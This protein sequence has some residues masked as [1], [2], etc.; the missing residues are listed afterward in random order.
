[1]AFHKIL[2][3]HKTVL[4][5]TILTGL[6]SFTMAQ[7]AANTAT[8]SAPSADAPVEA[9]AARK[10]AATVAPRPM[11]PQQKFVVDTVKMAT[12]LQQA[13]PQDRLRVLASAAGVV[14]VVD[15]KMAKGLWNE[16]ARVEIQ[17]IQTGQSPAV[18]V[19]AAGQADCS[20]TQNF[21]ENLPEASV[22][23]A[24]QSLIGAVTKCPKQTLETVARK[25]DA[26][27]EKKIIAPR[28]VMATMEAEGPKSPWSQSHFEKMF[29]SLP[30]AKDNAAEAENF[31]AMYARMAPEVEKNIVKKTGLELL[32]WLGKL[33]EGGLKTLSAN[34]VSGSMQQALGDEAFKD[35]LASNAVAGRVVQNA[36]DAGGDAAIERPPMET[37]SVLDALHANGTEQAER[38]RELPATL[39]AREAAA[40]GFA[41][42]TGGNKRQAEEYFD[43]AF[44]AIN[45]AWDARTPEQN[46]AA[47]VEE[48]S[49]AAAQVNSVDALSRAQKLRDSSAQAI[50]MLAVARVVAG[51][52]GK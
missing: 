13:D 26:A 8:G 5:A 18:S 3:F 17:L 10:G 50:A 25:L 12:S 45:E 44:A 16:G 36:H 14:S 22:A 6:S 7:T 49:E 38:L 51:G 9:P 11:T 32:E 1:M 41:A 40:H 2:V 46:T 37:V 30:D 35:A 27:M 20:V 42:G 15:S 4:T 21:T 34:I 47:V 43:M 28:A 19:M 33:D 24:E 48:V 39:R 29:D 52:S 31:A 23:A